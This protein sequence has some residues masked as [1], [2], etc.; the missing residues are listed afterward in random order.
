[1]LHGKEDEPSDQLHNAGDLRVPRINYRY[2][3]FV[4]APDLKAFPGE[5]LMPYGAGNN[6]RKEFLPFNTNSPFPVQAQL[7]RP[8]TLKPLSLQIAPKPYGAS[9]VGV[10]FLGLGVGEDS[11]KKVRP[12]QLARNTFHISRSLKNS[13]LSRMW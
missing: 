4:I 1:M 5:K 3:R 2:Y 9:G 13:L 10:Q 11:R 12:F 7:G 6:N 8:V